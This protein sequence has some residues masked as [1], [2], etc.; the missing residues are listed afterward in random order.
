[1]GSNLKIFI[2]FVFDFTITGLDV[3]VGAGGGI[4]I[5]GALIPAITG[6]N[7]MVFP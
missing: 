2:Y 6:G 1:M 3:V 7:I 5:I 4:D